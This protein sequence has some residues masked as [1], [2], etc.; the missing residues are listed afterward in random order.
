[1][2]KGGTSLETIN[3]IANFARSNIGNIQKIISD[4][5]SQFTSGEF[6]DW[7]NHMKIKFQS[8]TPT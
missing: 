4:R 5:G 7:M 6:G 1:M 2:K 3:A 8:S